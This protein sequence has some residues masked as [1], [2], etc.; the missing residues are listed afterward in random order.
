M[1]YYMCIVVAA[2]PR[3]RIINLWEIP[4]ILFAFLSAALHV[5]STIIKKTLIVENIA[6]YVY[7]FHQQRFFCLAKYNLNS[8]EWYLK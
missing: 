4:A 6:K 1:T 7:N 5:H 2:S 3:L 8:F